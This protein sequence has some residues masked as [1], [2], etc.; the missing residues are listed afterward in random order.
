MVNSDREPK[1]LIVRGYGINF[2]RC[3]LVSSIPLSN[4]ISVVSLVFPGAMASENVI[5]N[6]YNS[7]DA[8]EQWEYSSKRFKKYSAD[9]KLINFVRFVEIESAAIKVACEARKNRLVY[10]VI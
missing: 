6:P 4:T 7:S 5:T 10:L 1:W 2:F 9:L 3:T 8:S